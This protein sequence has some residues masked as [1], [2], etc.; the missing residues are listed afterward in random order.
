MLVLFLSMIIS[1]MVGFSLFLNH[2]ERQNDKGIYFAV[3]YVDA[4]SAKPKSID[5]SSSANE[6]SRGKVPMDVPRLT[7]IMTT[8]SISLEIFCAM[9]ISA[10]FS[11]TF[12]LYEQ[13]PK[14]L[15]VVLC[16]AWQSDNGGLF[17]GNLF[18]RH[19]FS[20]HISPNKTTEGIIGCFIL[21]FVSAVLMWLISDYEVYPLNYIYPPLGRDHYFILGAVVG[22]T[23]VV[24]DLTESFFK[25]AAGVKVSI[26]VGLTR[27]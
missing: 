10:T 26:V 14:I 7:L 8:L 27:A 19:K 22:V 2:W 13:Y 12:M 1:K 5:S 6:E 15:P 4:A 25:R 17:I 21:C 24:G 18:G 9:F 16:L 20:K 23:S 11:C 3:P